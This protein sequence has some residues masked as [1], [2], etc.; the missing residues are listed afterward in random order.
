MTFTREQTQIAYKK[1]PPEV[2]DFIMSND[3]TELISIF[4]NG[5]GLSEER[6]NLADSEILYAMYG[7][8]TLATAIAN[9]AELSN[10]DVSSLSKLKTNLEN[11]IFS[12]YKEL[13]VVT[14]KFVPQERPQEPDKAV[15]ITQE[16]KEEALEDLSRRVIGNQIV[17]PS[18]PEVPP[19]NLPMIEKGEVVH[20][21][22]HVEQP[23]TSPVIPPTPPA[24]VTPTTPNV[25]TEQP[26]VP[27]PDYRYAGGKDPYREP[28]K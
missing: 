28:I 27:V 13:G 22:P 6:A 15:V 20:D 24:P 19:S 7:I 25:K 4:L 21:V 2:Q 11:D 3:T 12:K 5:A 17:P 14:E 1:L 26:K 18:V 23:A 16:N 10:R 9:I 8:Q